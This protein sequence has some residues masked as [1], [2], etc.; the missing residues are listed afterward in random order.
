MQELKIVPLNGIWYVDHLVDG[1]P[2]A[3]VAEL[4]G[5]ESYLPTPFTVAVPLQEVV[6]EIAALNPGHKISI[7]HFARPFCHGLTCDWCG[8]AKNFPVAVKLE[9]FGDPTK[10]FHCFRCRYVAAIELDCAVGCLGSH[11]PQIL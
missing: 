2:D 8:Q 9:Y 11:R 10:P 5:G 7:S 3:D 6:A 1:A 4:F